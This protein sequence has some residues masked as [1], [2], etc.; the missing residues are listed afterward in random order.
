MKPW[1]AILAA[2]AACAA[3]C[4]APLAAGL[5]SLAAGSTRLACTDELAPL[6]IGLA[7]SGLVAGAVAWRR[8]R[9]RCGAV[10]GRSCEGCRDARCA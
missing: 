5:G 4:A 3:C 1:Q 2:I 6:A 10:V 9:A 8:R 7:A